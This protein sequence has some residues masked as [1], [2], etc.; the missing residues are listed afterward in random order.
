[1]NLALQKKS[2]HSVL[3]RLFVQFFGYAVAGA[4]FIAAA[5]IFYLRNFTRSDL[6]APGV[7]IDNISMGQKTK[8]QAKELVESQPFQEQILTIEYQ[9]QFWSTP[10]ATLGYKRNAD[11]AVEQAFEV[12]RNGGIWDKIHE[13]RGKEVRLSSGFRWDV[14]AAQ[15]WLNTIAEDL[16]V[17]G[18]KPSIT[19][20]KSGDPSSLEVQSGI[21]SQ[22]FNTAD[23][24]AQLKQL[25]PPFQPIPAQVIRTETT[26]DIGLKLATQRAAAF[27]GKK[28]S[29]RADGKNFRLSDQDIIKLM[30]PDGGWNI[31]LLT[32]ML[33]QWGKKVNRSP[34]EPELEIIDNKVKKFVPPLNGQELKIEDAASKL[35]KSLDD[36]EFSPDASTSATLL[37][38]E[39]PPQK[40][41]ESIN[42]LGIKEKIGEAESFY[43]HSIPGRVHNVSLTASR[44]NLALIAPGETFSFNKRLG[45]VSRRTGFRPAYV[46]SGGRT[47][48]GDGGG[49]CQVSSTTFRLA[50]NAG[51]P[52]V[53]RKGHSYRVSYYEENALPG[54]DATVYAPSPDL[55]FTND[56]GH[57]ILIYSETFPDDYYM[58][59]Q[60]WGASDGRKAQILDHKVYDVT[61]PGKTI[62]QED[63]TLPR[64]V[65]R[66]VDWSASGA[67][68]SFRYY[69]TRDGEELSNQIFKT[70]FQP[71]SAVYLVG[72]KD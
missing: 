70:V 11:H 8:K 34:Q 67:K 62:Y 7:F 16:R 58:Y 56:T 36:L 46:I 10:S 14:P 31:P 37:V 22:E 64:G 4:L 57:H 71:W 1:M 20:K 54:L 25:T 17:E 47:V 15:S 43:H 18:K 59:M 24:L 35:T 23:A 21:A 38:T 53:E 12:G 26:T 48:L 72:T 27:I 40:S 28:A 9:G 51:L 61:G 13:I 50:L 5:T 45:E 60:M 33:Q 44:I 39:R 52:I 6:I 30:E 65:K 2:K 32:A 3:T 55:K 42:T 69:V 29:Y 41:L 49:V 68:T 19:L 66:Q 63:P